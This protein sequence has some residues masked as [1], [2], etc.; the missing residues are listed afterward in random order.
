FKD[1][2]PCPL[3]ERCA[4]TGTRDIRISRREDLRQAALEELSDPAERDHLKRVRPRIE[5]LLP[6]LPTSRETVMTT[7]LLSPEG[8][9]GARD[10]VT[11]DERG[12]R[13]RSGAS[14]W[15]AQ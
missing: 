12:R 7:E 9:I 1:C 5:R 11:G 3:L 2:A 15:R 10:V 13:P 8:E 4:P 6:S 14:R